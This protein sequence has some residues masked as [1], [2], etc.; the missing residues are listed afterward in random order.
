MFQLYLREKVGRAEVRF[1]PIKALTKL[2]GAIEVNFSECSTLVVK[3]FIK[4]RDIV[5]KRIT[6]LFYKF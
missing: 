5:S 6:I 4:F 1:Y 2:L 3:F